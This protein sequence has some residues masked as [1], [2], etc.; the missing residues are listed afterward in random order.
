MFSIEVDRTPN[1]VPTDIYLYGG[2]WG[3][4]VGL[5]QIGAAGRAVGGQ[6]YT[7]ILA[8]YFPNTKIAG[9]GY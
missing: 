4:G 6:S 7:D 9:L 5:C 3:H 2:G 8:H 1:G